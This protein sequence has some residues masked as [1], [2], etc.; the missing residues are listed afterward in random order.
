MEEY[1]I[2]H[3]Y[4]GPCPG[5]IDSGTATVPANLTYYTIIGVYGFSVYNI[6][7]AGLKDGIWY[8]SSQQASTLPAGKESSIV[9]NVY[10]HVLLV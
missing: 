2:T 9:M 8:Q 4:V 6:T 5:S 3:T 1:E 7:V 10:I